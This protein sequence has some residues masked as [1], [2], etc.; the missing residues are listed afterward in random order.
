MKTL[1]IIDIGNNCEGIAKDSGKVYFVPKT[2]VGENVSVKVIKEKSNFCNCKVAD[3]KTKSA[4]RVIPKCEYF[5]ICGGCQLQHTSYA[6]QLKIKKQTTQNTINKISKLNIT[7][8]DV[9]SS[10][11]QLGYRNKMVF[12][13]NKDGKICMHDVEGNLFEVKHCHI[14]TDNINKIITLAQKYIDDYKVQSFDKKATKTYLRYLVVRELDNKFLI[15]FVI[16]KDNIKPLI[17]FAE[18]L[19]NSNITFGLFANVNSKNGSL[20]LT[21]KFIH[22]DGL[23]YI[24]SEYKTQSG[25]VIKYPISPASFMQVNNYVKDQIYSYVE[26]K[27]KGFKFVVDA[28]SGAGLLTA[29]ISQNVEQVVGIEVVK[30]ASKDADR[31]KQDNNINNMKN[32]NA[33]CVVGIDKVHYKGKCEDFAIVLDPPRKGA[34]QLVLEK[35]I[36]AR[37]GKIIYISCNPATLARDLVVLAKFYEIESA[38]S[39][40]MFA[41]TCEIETV[42]TLNIRGEK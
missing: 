2:L 21:E 22:I 40:D 17:K 35:V 38:K 3:V 32:I 34:D 11:Q 24:T 15:T 42:V 33:D 31:L 7:L 37:P 41:N 39:F 18:V 28:Y 1:D 23:K 9:V 13:I 30:Q 25:K 19:K 4:D 10:N 8:E 27:L 6:N 5:D 36:S 16:S 26:D 20:I 12:A 14:A 29:I